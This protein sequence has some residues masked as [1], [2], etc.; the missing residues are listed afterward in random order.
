VLHAF[1]PR[2]AILCVLPIGF[3]E[4]GGEIPKG[5]ATL[6]VAGNKVEPIGTE[7]GAEHDGMFPLYL[8]S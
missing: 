6:V 3:V 2:V 5:D 4:V 7:Y 8:V 1:L